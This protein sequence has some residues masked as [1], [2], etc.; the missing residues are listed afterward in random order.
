MTIPEAAQLVIQAGAM[1][2]G[3]DVFV[4]DMGEPVK[5]AELAGHLIRLSGLEPSYPDTEDDAP[6]GGDIE[7]RYTGLRPGEKLYEELLI[8][9]KVE[10]TSHARIM[11]ANE[12]SLDWDEMDCLLE[13]LFDAC[14][15]F[16]APRIRELLVRAPLGYQPQGELVDLVWEQQHLPQARKESA[17]RGQKVVALRA[18]STSAAS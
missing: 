7:I 13:T 10:A 15:A 14:L 3:G 2:R 18:H 11:T 1:A 9:E 6:A 4:L 8:G 12:I 16:D 5:I 17:A